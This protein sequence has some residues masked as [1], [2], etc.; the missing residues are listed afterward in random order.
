MTPSVR[1]EIGTAGQGGFHPHD[2]V[3]WSRDRQLDI[4]AG[5]DPSRFNQYTC[6]HKE[7]NRSYVGTFTVNVYA[8]QVR[9]ID[10]VASF[11]D[12]YYTSLTKQTQGQAVR[13]NLNGMPG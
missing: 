13:T 4:V 10:C 5:F 2:D 3:G 11:T 12:A 6:A 1:L 7:G 8:Y 9:R